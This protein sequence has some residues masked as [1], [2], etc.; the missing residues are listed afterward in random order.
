MY[1]CLGNTQGLGWATCIPSLPQVK[2]CKHTSVW[3]G[4]GNSQTPLVAFG[5]ARW[6]K[7]VHVGLV[8][9]Y[10]WRGWKPRGCQA[11]SLGLHGAGQLLLSR[12][13]YDVPEP[14]TLQSSPP[15]VTSLTQSWVLFRPEDSSAKWINLQDI[16]LKDAQYDF[17]TCH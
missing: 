16:K 14:I 4:P 12:K 17:L 11:A 5:E 2:A 1:L 10:G 7:E 3:E 13:A 9:Q 15:L 8:R 6:Y